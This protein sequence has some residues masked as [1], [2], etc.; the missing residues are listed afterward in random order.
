MKQKAIQQE[1]SGRNGYQL[2][3]AIIEGVFAP[4]IS[5]PMVNAVRPI[6]RLV[7]AFMSD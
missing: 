2:M 1:K 6:I 5:K 3:R 4:A 7:A